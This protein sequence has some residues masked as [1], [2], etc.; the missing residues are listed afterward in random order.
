MWQATDKSI[1]QGRDDSRESLL[2]KRVFQTITQLDKWQPKQT[3]D[4]IALLGFAS[5]TGVLRNL[6]REGAAKAPPILR[7]ALANLA[8][9]ACRYP[10]LDM[11][12]MSY[13]NADLEAGQADFSAAVQAIHLF[14]GKTLVFGGGH[15]TAFAHG[16]GLFDAYPEQSIAI[17]NFDPHLDLR[18]HHEATSGTPFLQLAE[19]AK[20]QQRVFNYTCIGAS[21]AN[22]TTVLLKEADE[23][24]VQTVW[25]TEVNWYQ[26]ENIVKQLKQIIANTDLIYLTIDLDV[27]P[28]YQMPAVS[29]PAALGIPLDLLMYLTTPIISSGKTVAADL[30]EYNPQFD[31]NTQGAR[32]AA[33]L[34]WHLWQHWQ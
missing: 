32:V 25:D 28:S 10:L 20:T 11:G 2:A 4:A 33:R 1:W 19:L 15:E 22:N 34:A 7:Q 23:L 17:I 30:V 6:G 18:R 5:D 24:N 26:A 8:A 13:A 12:D 14:S 16:K 27:L 29:A 21:R 9:Q 3:K 31:V